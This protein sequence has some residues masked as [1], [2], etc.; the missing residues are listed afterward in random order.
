MTLI[1]LITIGM[2]A[3]STSAK[4]SLRLKV[5]G[6]DN[7]NLVGVKIVSYSQPNEQLK[8]TGLTGSDGI[9]T[10]AAIKTGQYTFTINHADYVQQ[11]L[12]VTVASNNRE[13]TINM[14]PH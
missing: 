9:V 7:I 1:V 3:C 2:V 12:I 5:L 10:F 14:K 11:E 8:I 6:I 4:G 13:V